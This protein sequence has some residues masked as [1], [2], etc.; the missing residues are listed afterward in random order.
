MVDLNN[1]QEFSDNLS[2]LDEYFA[3]NRTHLYVELRELVEKWA[4]DKEKTQHYI[5]ELLENTCERARGRGEQ[6]PM[7]QELL[8]PWLSDIMWAENEKLSIGECAY[9]DE[10]I[11]SLLTHCNKY[12][13]SKEG[14]SDLLQDVLKYACQSIEENRYHIENPLYWLHRYIN[15]RGINW[16]DQQNPR[17][18]ETDSRRD[19]ALKEANVDIVDDKVTRR[20]VFVPLDYEELDQ[21]ENG[22][23]P[24]DEQVIDDETME[25][26]EGLLDLLAPNKREV[27][28]LF[29]IMDYKSGEIAKFLNKNQ[30]NVESVQKR[31]IF[32]LRKLYFQQFPERKLKWDHYI[33]EHIAIEKEQ[34]VMRL[35]ILEGMEGHK[36]EAMTAIPVAEVKEIVKKWYPLL[37]RAIHE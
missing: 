10:N 23:R 9:K 37:R 6:I 4:P 8:G 27:L 19:E 3:Q 34:K 30:E 12:T 33:S 11:R 18:P 14:A 2:R 24:T 7:Q 22:E 31:A 28:T 32:E 35:Y 16:Q 25:V 15:L 36:I 20:I 5:R 1:P 21:Q 17:M 26:L 29:Y 13:R